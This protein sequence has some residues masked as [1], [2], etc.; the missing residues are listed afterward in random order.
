M[1]R[2]E[3][4]VIVVLLTT[5]RQLP[6]NL[7][8]DEADKYRSTRALVPQDHHCEPRIAT[9]ILLPHAKHVLHVGSDVIWCLDQQSRPDL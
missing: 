2:L 3:L 6:E 8:A 5:R 9:N 4:Q 7:A 1:V